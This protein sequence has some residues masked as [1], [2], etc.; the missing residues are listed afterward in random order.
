MYCPTC[1]NSVADGLKY[2]N[3]CGVQLTREVEDKD[4]G[5]GKMLN[6]LL[7]VLVFIVL[8]GMGILVGL[9]AVMLGNDVKVEVVTMITT[10]YL[11]AIFGI[12][13]MLARQVPKLIDARLTRWS[14]AT[15]L[16]APQQLETR[17]TAQL[18]EHRQPVASVTDHTTKTLDK[19]PLA[20]R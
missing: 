11:L 7:T 17:T 14:N 9:V 15:D 4:F 16:I 20:R 3:S 18:E 12:C 13:F 2:C 10:A 8:F 5:P 6:Y 19:V 1:G